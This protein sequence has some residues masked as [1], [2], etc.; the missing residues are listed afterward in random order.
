MTTF[1][2]RILSPGIKA[3]GIIILQEFLWDLQSEFLSEKQPA[4]LEVKFP[5]QIFVKIIRCLFASR[6]LKRNVSI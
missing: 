3:Y 2:I 5:S 4:T 6:K 1:S